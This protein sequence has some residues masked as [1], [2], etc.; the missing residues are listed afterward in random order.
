ML[1]IVK[2]VIISVAIC[3]LFVAVAPA[4][5][6]EALIA[7]NRY[8]MTKL[9]SELNDTYM[10]SVQIAKLSCAPAG[11]EIIKD[12]ESKWRAYRDAECKAEYPLSTADRG[13]CLISMTKQRIARLKATY[14][15]AAFTLNSN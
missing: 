8:V 7:R 10:R 14:L 4:Q 5:E 15:K 2:Q 11:L 13:E 12:S 6:D 3:H 9:E 1:R